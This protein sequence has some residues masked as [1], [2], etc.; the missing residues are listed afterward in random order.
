MKSSIPSPITRASALVALLWAGVGNAQI[1]T[2]CL[3]LESVLVDACQ[4]ACAGAQEGENEM[5][6]FITGPDP[7][8]LSDI[9][10]QWAT[11]NAFLGWVQN[12]TTA[13]LTGQLN[14]TIT[15]CGWLIEPPGGIIPA[16][17]RVL[18][19]TSTDMC[20]AG[21]S[22]ADLSDTL[23]VIFQEAGNTFGHFKNTNNGS[24]V[25]NTPSG[26]QS[27]RT[28]I[29][30]VVSIQ[31]S[32]S[33][34]YNLP[35]LVNQLGTYGGSSP[36]NDGSGLAISWPGTPVLDYFNNGC[37]APVTQFSATITSD[38]EPMP[39]GASALLNAVTVGNVTSS[40]WSG[41]S[42][43]FSNTSGTTTTY[44]LGPTETTST[45][46]YFCAVS[47]CGDTVCD[48][49]QLWVQGTP[50]VVI[51]PDGP[52]S[53]CSGSTV[54]LVASGASAYTWNTGAQT[55]VITVDTAGEYIVTASSSCGEVSDTIAVSITDTPI[56][57]VEGPATACP[58]QVVHLIASGG[59]SYSWSTGGTTAELD[60]TGPGTW[61]VTVSDVCGSDNATITVLPG[62]LVQP[63]FTAADTE[64]CAPQCATFQAQDLGDVDYAWNFSDGGLAT[65]ASASHCFSVG[66]HDV[67]LTVSPLG[68]DTRC[69][70]TVVQ[71]GLIHAWPLPEARFSIEPRAV[72]IEDPMVL[73]N[74]GSSGASIWLWHFDAFDDST[75][76]ERSPVMRYDAVDCYNITLEATSDL[77]CTDSATTVLCVEEPFAV[78]IPNAFTPNNDGINDSFRATPTTRDPKVFQLDLYD[79]WGT[80]IFSG[81]SPQSAWSGDGFPDGIYVWKLRM[82]DADGKLHERV[83]HVALIR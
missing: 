60:V 16:G 8:A 79:R 78:Y 10:V 30:Y 3:E 2:K 23:Y 14:A 77:G 34:T 4:S 52:T 35:Q 19:I 63:T 36:Q 49:I 25:S 62:E 57:S 1:P 27:F 81:S 69:P 66:Y 58:A 26:T 17:K 70:A 33:V 20:V 51:T 67:T 37:Q 43:T 15:N 64:G 11:P 13:S 80:V 53:I 45:L 28:F 29:L 18:G 24:G 71:A 44:T 74:N 47:A 75:S 21:N 76:T 22:F 56:A 65:G 5:F 83:G 32:D 12:A 59:S 7:I 41:G 42:G 31:C 61:T 40:Y 73:F 6:R 54:D 46:L 68:N 55:A 48:Q 9:E 50:N 39:C 38:V 82:Q 72:T